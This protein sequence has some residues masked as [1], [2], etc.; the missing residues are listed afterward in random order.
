M[1]FRELPVNSPAL[2]GLYSRL[3]PTDEARQERVHA[4]LHDFYREMSTDVLVGFFFANKDL[5]AIADKQ[6]EFLLRA[7]GASPSYSGK[8]PAR[9]HENL[10]P[11]LS[12]HFDRR[13]KILEGVL[14]RHGL[15]DEDIRTWIGFEN[16]FRDAIV[17]P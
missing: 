3:G 14:T 8:P 11:I 7:M 10:A 13:L 2:R 12:G 5:N 9:A 6:A 16:A 4:I 1:S 15:N 17:K